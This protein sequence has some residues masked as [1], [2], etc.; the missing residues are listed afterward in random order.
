MTPDW[1]RPGVQA[2]FIWIDGD[3]ELPGGSHL[4]EIAGPVLES[5]Q[6]SPFFVVATLDQAK[7]ADQLYRGAVTPEELRQFLHHCRIVKGKVGEE[8]DL[9]ATVEEAALLPLLD[10]WA[11]RE[12]GE[13]VSYEEEADA[14]LY[15]DLPIHAT[16]DAYQALQHSHEA[17]VKTWVCNGC[18]EPEDASNFFWTVHRASAIQVRLVIQNVG[19]T[20]TWWLHPFRIEKTMVQT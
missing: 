16:S 15:G 12:H 2:T 7:F 4:Y 17:L 14:F 13:L 6:A 11:Q 18:G 8:L 1:I 10:E 20:W 3:R 19:G 9:L 5:Q